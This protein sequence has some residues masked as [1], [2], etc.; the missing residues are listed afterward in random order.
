MSIRSIARK[1]STILIGNNVTTTGKC[2]LYS[3]DGAGGSGIS[4]PGIIIGDD[5]MF[6]W[7]I[8]V[9]NTDAHP[10]YRRSD[11]KQVNEP[12]SGLVCI[13]PHVWIGQNSYIMKDVTI[14]ACSIIGLGSVVTKSVPRF[15]NAKGIPAKYT[16]DNDIYWSRS[17]GESFR[18]KALSYTK[19]FIGYEN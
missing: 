9:R 8:T 16:V 11:N 5:C 6:A 12:N 2:A 14:G 19:K 15:S 3:G 7:D 10:I 1:K 17:N 13:E 18:L 4:T